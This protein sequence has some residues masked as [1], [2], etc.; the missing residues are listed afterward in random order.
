[1]VEALADFKLDE[2]NNYM[3]QVLN[4][5]PECGMCYASLFPFDDEEAV[6]N[7]KKAASMKL[8]EDERLLIEGVIAQRED[9]PRDIGARSI[10]SRLLVRPPDLRCPRRWLFV[11]GLQFPLHSANFSRR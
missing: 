6:A 7:L 5:D 10:Q 8:S 4:E 3:R 2:G 1:M 11:H 9:R